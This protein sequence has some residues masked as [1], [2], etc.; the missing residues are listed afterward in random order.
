MDLNCNIS[1][2]EAFMNTSLESPYSH[3][4]SLRELAVNLTS[5]KLL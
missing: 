1:Q 5:G 3:E 2:E 4:S